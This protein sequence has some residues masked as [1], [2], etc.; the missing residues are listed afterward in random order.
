MKKGEGSFADWVADMGEDVS[1]EIVDGKLQL[2]IHGSWRINHWSFL[3]G[4]WT[5]DMERIEDEDQVQEGP[6]V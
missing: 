5:W 1:A 2:T 3:D 4:K 6:K